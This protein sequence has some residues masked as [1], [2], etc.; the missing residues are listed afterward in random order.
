MP[1]EINPKFEKISKFV[2]ERAKV[3]LVTYTDRKGLIKE[4]YEAL[5]LIDVAF[6]KLYG[7]VP[8]TDR[9]IDDAIKNNISLVNL[10]YVCSIKDEQ[11]E[12]VG[13]A[14]MVPS[15]AK[16]LKKSNGRLFPLGVF[17]LLKALSCKNDTLEMYF[18]GVKPE[19]QKSGVAGILINHML[20]VCVNNGVKYCETGPELETNE[21]VQS[22]WKSFDAVNHKRRRCFIKK[23]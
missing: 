18:V 14:L 9:V 5:K 22:M 11:N 21:A 12:I 6:S 10:D 1:K 17:R 15:I 16:A 23:I 7:T 13:F 2:T 4:A 19:L 3:K 8:L 20:K